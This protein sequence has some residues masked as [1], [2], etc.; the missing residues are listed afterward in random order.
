MQSISRAKF[1]ET[2]LLLATTK[3]EMGKTQFYLLHRKD[4]GYIMTDS[5]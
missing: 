5:H 3:K 2:R 4:V 1:N